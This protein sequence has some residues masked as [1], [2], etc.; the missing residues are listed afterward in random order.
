[1]SQIKFPGIRSCC[2]ALCLVICAVWGSP[3]AQAFDATTRLT[4]V[5]LTDRDVG[6]ALSAGLDRT[7]DQVFPEQHYGVRVIVD[8]ID[9][10]NGQMVIY[11]SLG[12]A[13]RT[14]N[15]QHWQQHATT[16]HAL[17]LPTNLSPQQQHSAVMNDLSKLAG[18]FSQAMIQNASRVR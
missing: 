17:I 18:A 5:A 15:G 2:A 6:Q 9:L 16:S 13:R 11:M 7:F 14:S 3:D 4:H 10:R 8:G 1:M 12:L